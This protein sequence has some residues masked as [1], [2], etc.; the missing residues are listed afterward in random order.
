MRIAIGGFQHETNTFAP[1]KA[2][3]DDFELSWEWRIAR[4][5]NNGVKYLVTED[6]PSAPGHEY[7]M[8]D[9]DENPDGKSGPK[10]QTAAFY[11][12]LPP[13]PNKPRK[14]VGQWNHIEITCNRNLIDVVLNG[15]K[16]NHVDLDLFTE[17]NKRPDGSAHKFDVAYKDHPRTGYIG[18]QDHGSPCWFKN[19]KLRPLKP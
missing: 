15:D 16:V 13:V 5:G 18:L 1:R 11:D 10:R 7:Q 6:R 14:P 3:F 19:I 17:R 8:I 4:A 9:D 2:T 12:V